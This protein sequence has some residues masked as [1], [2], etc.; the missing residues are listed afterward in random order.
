MSTGQFVAGEENPFKVD[1]R[2]QGIPQDAVTEDRESM[3]KCQE[4]VDKLR[5]EH[6]TESIV[7]DL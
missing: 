2:I 1:F 4:L 5:T 6:Q 3:S 7:A